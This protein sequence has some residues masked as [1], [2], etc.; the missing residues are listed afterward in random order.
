MDGVLVDFD[1][2]YFELTGKDIKGQWH[3]TPEFWNPINE[4]G[5]KFWDN[6]EWT[7]DGK[8]LWS[9][10]EEHYPV[11]L[12]SPSRNGYGSRK[13]KNSWVNRELP[14]VPLLL[15]YSNNKKKY[16]GTN[17][18]LIDDRDRNIDQWISNGGIGILHK[19]YDT[20]ISQLEKLGL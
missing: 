8:R 6:L 7:K 19:D 11:L 16:A 1:K 3:T 9:Y 17:C 10:L 15:E 20:T 13:G 5:E 2:G 4:Q 12:S 14:G 18:I